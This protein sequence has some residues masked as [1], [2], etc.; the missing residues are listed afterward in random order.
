MPVQSW[1]LANYEPTQEALSEKAISF[2]FEILTEGRKQSI[3]NL[4]DCQGANVIE[5]KSQLINGVVYK[6]T[7][8][9]SWEGIEN[10]TLAT[11]KEDK[12]YRIKGSVNADKNQEGVAQVEQVINTFEIMKQS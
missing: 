2:E 5:C 10:I 1:E 11:V 12:I 7:I 8:T 9:R 3:E 6:E 4:L